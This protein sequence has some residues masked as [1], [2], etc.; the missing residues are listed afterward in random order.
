[1]EQNK[2]RIEN[3][4]EGTFDVV[5]VILSIPKKALKSKNH[6]EGDGNNMCR[7]MKEWITDERNAGIKEGIEKGIE[8]GIKEGMKE[9]EKHFAKLASILLA[10]KRLDD[11]NKAVFDEIFRNSL[12]QE[13]NI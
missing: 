11:L 6:T 2:E 9:G 8:K 5:R 4:D 10:S 12:Y 13:F 7:A 1:M 3:M